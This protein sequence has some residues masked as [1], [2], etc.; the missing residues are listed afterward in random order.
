[1]RKALSFPHDVPIN[2]E[3]EI[4]IFGQKA[5]EL[6]L[7]VAQDQSWVFLPP[8]PFFALLRSALGQC[9][10]DFYSGLLT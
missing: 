2:L 4:Q 6:R 1:V 7:P 10:V 9:A 3:V 8:L 5:K